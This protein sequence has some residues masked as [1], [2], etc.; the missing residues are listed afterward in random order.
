MCPLYVVAPRVLGRFRFMVAQPKK[1]T[2]AG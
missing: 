1:T 2:R